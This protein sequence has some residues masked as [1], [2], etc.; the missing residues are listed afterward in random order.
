MKIFDQKLPRYWKDRL[1]KSNHKSEFS[2]K[3]LTVPTGSDFT[4]LFT[5]GKS[6]QKNRVVKRA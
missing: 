6:A 5:Q 1:Q 3:P 4:P 2:L